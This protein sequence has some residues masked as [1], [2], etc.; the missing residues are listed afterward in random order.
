MLHENVVLVDYAGGGGNDELTSPDALSLRTHERKK[1]F[2]TPPKHK[3]LH[4]SS[5]SWARLA[6]TA[7]ADCSCLRTTSS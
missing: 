4:S 1:L 6:L 5:V 2:A 3:S 7:V